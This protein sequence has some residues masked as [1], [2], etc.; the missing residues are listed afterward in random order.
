MLLTIAEAISEPAGRVCRWRADGRD[1]GGHRGRAARL[2]A[3]G[4]QPRRHPRSQL[5]SALRAGELLAPSLSYRLWNPDETFRVLPEPAHSPDSYNKAR[6][7]GWCGLLQLL[8]S[9]VE[10]IQRV[11]SGV[12]CEL[13]AE[14]EGAEV[15]E[16]EGATAPL[17]E[18]LHSR[19][20]GVGTFQWLSV[21]EQTGFSSEQL[22]TQL[23]H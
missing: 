12:L 20:E 22:V 7:H 6:I 11:A 21:P 10:N 8:Y 19:N 9:T 18:L 13:A 3:R 23:V 4:S 5:H 1:R 2:G 17:T 14:K 16:Q 15:I